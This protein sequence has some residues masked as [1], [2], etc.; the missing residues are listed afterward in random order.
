MD[1]KKLLGAAGA[2]II[3]GG[4]LLHSEPLGGFQDT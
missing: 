2:K 3:R 4:A 1:I